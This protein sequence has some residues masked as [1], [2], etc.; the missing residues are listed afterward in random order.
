[1]QMSA[2]YMKQTAAHLERKGF[3]VNT[4]QDT[5]AGPNGTIFERSRY[6]CR[7]TED[8]YFIL[9]VLQYAADSEESYFLEI[10]RYFNLYSHSFP[11]DSWKFRDHQIEFKYLADKDSG[12]GLSFVLKL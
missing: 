8:Q 9:E 11:L 7:K 3:T 4:E 12:L 1:M 6:H 2:A 5:K 10:C